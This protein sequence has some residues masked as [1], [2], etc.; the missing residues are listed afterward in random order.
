MEVLF[1]VHGADLTEGDDNDDDEDKGE[2]DVSRAEAEEE[3]K[4]DEQDV[5]ARGKELATT[6]VVHELVMV[7]EF[8][9]S[10]LLALSLVVKETGPGLREKPES[11]DP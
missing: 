8:S 4:E 1:G 9:R 6:D 11:G 3:E 2:K 5:N 10:Q 7:C